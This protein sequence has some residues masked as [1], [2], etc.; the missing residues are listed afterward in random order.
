M[1]ITDQTAEKVEAKERERW[2]RAKA[3]GRQRFIW[4]SGVLGWGLVTFLIWMPLL[5]WSTRQLNWSDA[6]HRSA[7][8]LPIWLL[9]GYIYGIFAWKRMSGKYAD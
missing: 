3:K 2:L 4:R 1:P 5:L 6:L 7:V 9:G 8:S